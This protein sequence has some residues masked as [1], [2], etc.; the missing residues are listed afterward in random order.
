LEKQDTSAT[1]EMGYLTHDRNDTSPKNMNNVDSRV[2]EF[3]GD[4]DSFSRIPYS[5]VSLGVLMI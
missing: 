4:L 2:Y 1:P 5:K 3:K